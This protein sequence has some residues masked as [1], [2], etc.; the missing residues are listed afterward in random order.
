L[1][2]VAS[3]VRELKEWSV[4]H[5]ERHGDE[6][7]MLQLVLTQLH[8][9]DTNHH[10]RVSTIKR[11]GVMTAAVSLLYVAMELLRRFFLPF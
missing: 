9:H 6:A 11:G 7:G 2:D 4:R 5:E 3:D 1:D 10:G 8:E